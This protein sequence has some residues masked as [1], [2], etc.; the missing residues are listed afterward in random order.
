MILLYIDANTIITL[1]G[2]VSVILLLGGI[3]LKIHKWYL[4]QENQAAEIQELK[5]ENRLFCEAMFAM[6]DGLEQL[7]ANHTV[8]ETKHK[9]QAHLNK[10]AH[11]GGS[12]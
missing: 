6:L 11:I 2:L 7:G 8:T 5:Q 1:G 10:Q 12:L 9:L 4:R 3:L